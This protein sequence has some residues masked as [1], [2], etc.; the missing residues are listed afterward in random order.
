MTYANAHSQPQLPDHLVG[1]P[2]SGVPDRAGHPSRSGLYYRPN[3]Q[4]HKHTG[5]EAGAL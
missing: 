2:R 4:D 5:F 3:E 1:D